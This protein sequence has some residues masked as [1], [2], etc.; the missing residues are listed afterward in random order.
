VEI[1]IPLPAGKKVRAPNIGVSNPLRKRSAV[2]RRGAL[3]VFYEYTM[4]GNPTVGVSNPLRKRSAVAK[5]G[6]LFVFIYI[7]W[8]ATPL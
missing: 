4:G 2:A 3:F 7:Q 5:R 1:G 8:E 6:A